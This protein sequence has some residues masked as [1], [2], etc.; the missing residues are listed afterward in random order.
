MPHALDECF[1]RVC[2]DRRASAA[3]HDLTDA[4]SLTFGDLHDHS[5]AIGRALH[6]LGIGPGAT[7][8]TLVGNRPLFFPLVAAC[9]A[10]RTAIVPLGD[11]T[12]EEAISVIDRAGA[13][14]VVTDRALR[15]PAGGDRALPDGFRL[16]ALSTRSAASHGESVVLKLT[17]GSTDVPKAAIAS[18]DHLVN[19][20]R[21]VIEAMAIEPTDVNLANIPVSHSYALGNVVMPLL[22]QGTAVALRQ[23]FN[24]GQLV[25]DV[26]SAGATIFPGVPFM[27]DRFRTLNV[28]QLPARLR[29]LITAGAPID[30]ETVR[31]FHRTL[32]RK[33]HSFY[34]SSETGGIA[35]DD[36]DEVA[37]PL[38]VGRPMPETTVDVRDPDPSGAGRIFVSGT[39]VANGYAGERDGDGDSVFVDGGFLTSDLGGF[40]RYGGL[41]LT[42]RVSSLVNV[43][44]LKVDPAEIE[45]AL[46][47]VAGIAAVR[48]IGASCERRGQQLV[49]FVIA[50]RPL[51]PVDLRQRCARTLSPHKIPRQFIF[52]EQFPVDARGKTDRRALEAL[53]AAA[54]A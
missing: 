6:D 40:D 12:D 50:D 48:V 46:L 41:V 32:G 23:S 20:G 54:P 7:V 22:I 43:A 18:A 39:A 31:W 9:L 36:S 47:Q 27:Y 24:P 29:L 26:A 17:S 28:D 30:P 38:D 51:T 45:R 49:A 2:R 11:T 19:D 34:G 42:G 21:H 10:A 3:I 16:V 44:G 53:V 14:A 13:H 1:R 33:I 5:L 25:A 4:R 37:D 52:L 35:Y 8:V 15:L